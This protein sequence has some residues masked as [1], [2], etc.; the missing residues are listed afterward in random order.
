MIPSKSILCSL[1]AGIA[2]LPVTAADYT[3]AGVLLPKKEAQV[4]SF[5]PK[6]ITDI[7]LVSVV[8]QGTRVSKGQT[9]AVSD[10]KNLNR[11]IKAMERVVRSKQLD[12]E[13][14]K[15]ELEQDKILV[16]MKTQEAKTALQRMDEDLQDFKQ[17][18]QARMLAE[19]DEKVNRAVRNRS[20]KKEEL[21][22]LKQMYAE[23][24]VA[25]ETEEVILTRLNNEFSEADFAVKGAE[26]SASIAKTRT[27]KRYAEDLENARKQKELEV[28][29]IEFKNQQALEQKQIAFEEA[30]TALAQAKEQLNNMKT[31]VAMVQFQ[32]PADGVVIYGGYVGNRWTSAEMVT[33]LRPGGKLVPYDQ[34]ATIV[35]EN[36]ELIVQAVLPETVAAPQAGQPVKVKIAGKEFP[37]TVIES[38]SVPD[39]SGKRHIIVKPHAATQEIFVPCLPVQV[40]ISTPQA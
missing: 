30:E 29:S 28:K 8:P 21:D 16:A 38:H 7:S 34:V 1:L 27:I 26:L 4:I 18:R 13:K 3:V 14:V 23:D 25:V 19:E 22:Q 32:S 12:F 11:Q 39:A 15:F 2:I 35:P 10:V 37:G 33:K 17:K 36:S 40:V 31:D 6:A 9:V 5:K 24:Q 20:Y